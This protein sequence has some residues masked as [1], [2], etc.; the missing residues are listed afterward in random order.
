MMYFI[1]YLNLLTYGYDTLDEL[2]FKDNKKKI[3]KILSNLKLP[4]PN[5]SNGEQEIINNAYSY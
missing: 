3:C 4:K 2:Y 5:N 1:M